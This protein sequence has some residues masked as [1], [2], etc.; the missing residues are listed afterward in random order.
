M[1]I[2]PGLWG[3]ADYVDDQLFL[4]LYPNAPALSGA[5][6]AKELMTDHS[7]IERILLGFTTLI[8]YVVLPLLMLYLIA[9]AGG[10]ASGAKMTSEAI[11]RP[12]QE[13]GGTVSAGVR[14]ARA[15][16][17]VKGL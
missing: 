17:W 5:G 3:F 2:L 9:E 14:G 4:A 1:S 8:F 10:P 13:Q 16:P 12:S 15:R 7:T 11:N 6:I